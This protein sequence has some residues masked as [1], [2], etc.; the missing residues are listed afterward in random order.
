M[1][2][3]A[4]MIHMGVGNVVANLVDL[5]NRSPMEHDVVTL[6]EGAQIGGAYV[7]V[8]VVAPDERSADAIADSVFTQKYH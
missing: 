6:V 7:T 4:A 5:A 8:V 2:N 3:V 1:E